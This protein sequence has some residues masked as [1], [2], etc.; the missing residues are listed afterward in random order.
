TR[1][2]PGRVLGPTTLRGPAADRR[3]R[4][5]GGRPPNRKIRGR[6]RAGDSDRWRRRD[7]RACLDWSGSS[8]RMMWPTEPTAER[9]VEV[10][11]FVAGPLAGMTLAGLGC[12][13]LRVDPPGGGLDFAR[14]PITA[15]G[16]SIF[17]AGLNRG[18]RSVVIDYRRDKGRELVAALVVAGGTEGGIFLTNLGAGGA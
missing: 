4:K 5:D 13:V 11:A 12:E 9:I 8:G 16:E 6:P 15:S 2:L 1:Q 18:K 3:T 10:S 7:R 17:W 14:W